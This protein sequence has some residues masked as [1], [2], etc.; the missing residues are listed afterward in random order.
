M[1]PS[2]AV[3]NNPPKNSQDAQE[4]PSTTSNQAGNVEIAN[5]EVDAQTITAVEGTLTGEPKGSQE[6]DVSPSPQPVI[7]S[8]EESASSSSED[9]TQS[10]ASILTTTLI[11]PNGPL[12]RPISNSGCVIEEVVPKPGPTEVVV[13]RGSV[14]ST[15]SSKS[16][17]DAGI[18][19]LL[20]R[21]AGIENIQEL[22]AQAKSSEDLDWSLD[23]C[24]LASEVDYEEYVADGFSDEDSNEGSVYDEVLSK[25]E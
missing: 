10:N 13:G 11:L 22:V 14:S 24:S 23:D 4:N 25:Q 2:V 18:I 3:E 8:E 15:I 20:N 16:E 1:A 19:E 5:K 17:F 21:I 9:D 12:I 6:L 7:Q